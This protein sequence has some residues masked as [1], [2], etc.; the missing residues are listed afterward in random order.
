RFGAN[1]QTIGTAV[2]LVTTGILVGKYRPDDSQDEV[3]IR[4]R[5]PSEARGIHA[6]DNLRVTAPDGTMVPMSNFVTLRP[7]QQVNSIERVDGHRVYHVR[8]N[9]KPGVNAN[10]EIDNIKKWLATQT[11]PADVHVAFKG[12]SEQQDESQAFLGVAALMALFL[13]ALV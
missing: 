3:E 5:Y 13:I 7:A 1:A 4:V 8:A 9:V 2:Q 11:F 10:A 6:L 12:G